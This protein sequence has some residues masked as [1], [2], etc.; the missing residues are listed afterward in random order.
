MPLTARQYFTLRR[1]HSLT[2]IVP[3]GV[4]LCEHFF[5]N[6]FALQGAASYNQKVEFL[7][8]LPY[9]YLIELFGIAVPILFHAV[10]GVIILLE[11]RF[12]STRLPYARNHMF[13]WQR[14]TGLFLIAFIAYHVLTTR[15]GAWFGIDTGDMFKLMEHKMQTPALAVLYLLGVLAASFHFGNGL[16]GFALHWGVVTGRA[17]Q[18]AW[19]WVAICVALLFAVAGVNFW[20]AFHPFGLEGVTVFNEA[21]KAKVEAVAPAVPAAPQ[22][23]PKPEQPAPAPTTQPPAAGQTETK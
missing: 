3:I 12:N 18:R 16:W 11:A 8:S 5:T 14:F 20:M 21:E 6:S 1:L 22:P 15:F 17:A 10:L 2:G 13:T 9:L 7:K 19:S 4:F 23:Q